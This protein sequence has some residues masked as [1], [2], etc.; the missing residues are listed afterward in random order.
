LNSV[1]TAAAFGVIL[2]HFD[3]CASACATSSSL[4]FFLKATSIEL[5]DC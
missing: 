5:A 1:T 2:M 3:A 4:E